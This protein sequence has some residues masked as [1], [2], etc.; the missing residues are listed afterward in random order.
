MTTL[1]K[2]AQLPLL[3]NILKC[4]SLLLVLLFS[5]LCMQSAVAQNQNITEQVLYSGISQ[6]DKSFKFYTMQISTRYFTG[7]Q[8][9]AFKVVSEAYDSDPDIFISKVRHSTLNSSIRPINS[10][11]QPVIVNG[12]A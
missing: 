4:S 6:G 5:L 10:Q 3:S 1:G 2:S 8:S 11:S 9:L 12:T 7:S